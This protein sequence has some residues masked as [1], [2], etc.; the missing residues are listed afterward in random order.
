MVVGIKKKRGRKKEGVLEGCL[1]FSF[2]L[3]CLFSQGI[4]LVVI[5]VQIWLCFLCFEDSISFEFLKFSVVLLFGRWEESGLVAIRVRVWS[6]VDGATC[7]M[8]QI[9]SSVIFRSHCVCYSEGFLLNLCAIKT[10]YFKCRISLIMSLN[11]MIENSSRYMVETYRVNLSVKLLPWKVT[12][13]VLTEVIVSH[14]SMHTH[15]Q[16]VRWYVFYFLYKTK[17]KN[18]VWNTL[19]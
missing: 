3:F 18:K 5:L 15:Q 14:C 10:L 17:I 11:W 7:S 4:F 9:K 13:N 8:I 16:I 2:L 12:I 19:F 1:L 6:L